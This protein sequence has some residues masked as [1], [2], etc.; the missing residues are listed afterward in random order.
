MN[1]GSHPF[2]IRNSSN[3]NVTLDSG[4]QGT[5]NG[6]LTWTPS[7][8]GT[9]YYI[10]GSHGSM[11]ADIIVTT[12]INIIAG[13][14][15]IT[16]NALADNTYSGETV[17]F[18]DAA[19]NSSTLTLTTFVVDTVAPTLTETTPISTPSNDTTPSVVITSNEA[20]TISSSLGFSSTTS[21]IAGAN[22]ITFNTLADNTY[23]GET[24][25]FTD[26]VGNST[27]LTLSTFII[28]TAGPVL[29]ETTPV[30]TPTND[31]TPSVVIT[32]N[33]AGTITSSTL[34][35]STSS[36]II[37][38]ANTITFNTLTDKTYSG[39]SITV[40][41]ALGNP[42]TLTLTSF[43][44]DTVAPTLTE[45]TPIST[46]S[47][48]NK[49]SVVITSD[50]A[51]TISSSLSFTST[52]SGI[53]G[54]NTITFDTLADNTYNGETVTFTDAAGN[55]KSITLTAFTISTP[56]Q[57]YS[58]NVVGYNFY[59][60]LSGTDRGGSVSGTHPQ[61][62]LITGDTVNFNVSMNAGNHPFFIR[63]SSNNNVTLDSGTQGTTNG[64]LT[65][66]P[67]TSGTYY[68]ICGAHGSMRGDII[69]STTGQS[70]NINVFGYN[71]Y[72]ALSG[73]DRGG[74]VSGTHAQVDLNTGDTVNFNVSMIAGNHPFFIRNSS[75]NNVTL[76]SGTQG[77]TNGTLTWT[78]TVSGTYYYVC[79]AHGSMRADIVVS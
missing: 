37:A 77:T 53:V 45:T 64:T 66:T 39:D 52:T 36:N 19:G 7:E 22:T 28:N 5:T 13:A 21:G 10:C 23:S 70:Y 18:T 11:R 4:T 26:A 17:T 20:G 30:S 12:S 51:G 40:T 78:P 6:T 61:V 42:S 62:D 31:N 65:W 74:S 68:Y 41:D 15:T 49:P 9:Y 35:F 34:G 58:I 33:K 63:N 14:N 67:S 48:N 27:T 32:S 57:S 46:P 76:D 16:F 2:F 50:E 73:N 24:V 1:A 38:G 59:Y 75:N 25:T 54:A 60:T 8:S 47:T 79:G 3:N 44:I 29:S 69:V 72:Y 43:T 55:S 56:G 71:F